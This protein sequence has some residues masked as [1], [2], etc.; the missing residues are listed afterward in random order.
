MDAR[1]T[2]ALKPLAV[3][4]ALANAQLASALVL[5]CPEQIH[6]NALNTGDTAETTTLQEAL[7][8][9][10]NCG[11]ESVVTINIADDL[12]GETEELSVGALSL[13]AS[14]SLTINGPSNGEFTI[15]TSVAD[16]VIMSINE[17]AVLAVNDVT[18]AGI[19]GVTRSASLF[20]VQGGQVSFSGVGFRDI[21][22][23]AAYSALYI[24]SPADIA[25]T[26]VTA[27]GNSSTSGVIGGYGNSVP[28]DTT[29]SVSDSVFTNN[30]A[31]TSRGGAIN[32]FDMDLTIEDSVF[33]SNTA[34]GDNGYSGGGAIYMGGET[35]IA[36]IRVSD[37]TFR[38]NQARNYGGAIYQSTG[39]TLT[40][41]D[42][43][44]E[45]NS[46][47]AASNEF[48]TGASAEAHGGA[49]TSDRST[50]VTITRTSFIGND[51]KSY[52][53]AVYVGRSGRNGTVSIEDSTFANNSASVSVSESTLANGGAIYTDAV[54]SDAYQLNIRRSTF[55]GNNAEGSAGALYA[56]GAG[57]GLLVENS[58][59]DANSAAEH[60]GGLYLGALPG[61]SISHVT[62]TDNSVMSDANIASGFIFASAPTEHIEIS[63]SVFHGN[64]T[65]N[66]A[67]GNICV[68]SEYSFDAQLSHSFWNGINN[69][70]VGCRTPVTDQTVISS[71]SDPL[72]G[73][74]QD[75]GGDTRTRYPALSSVLVDAGDANIQEAPD[76]DQRG[77]VRVSRGSIDIGAVEYGNLPPEVSAG[78]AVTVESGESISISLSDWFTDPEN[79][80]V[81]FTAEGA[82]SWLTLDSSTGEVT[83]TAGAAGSYDIEVTAQDEFG[84]T[85]SVTV[86]VVVSGNTDSSS[87]SSGGAIATWLLTLLGSLGLMRKRG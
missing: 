73:S 9:A 67:A 11:T 29:V 83:G 77:S 19:D 51:A 85:T 63:H 65:G 78:E 70:A 25:L 38:Q 37:S 18:F 22:G 23:T 36:R 80:S 69:D 17:S 41:E 71:V 20:N 56:G 6:V 33:D 79:D 55:S 59:F 75:N 60:S 42:T 76:T 58:T 47:I 64:T 16:Q 53:G 68:S 49:I 54:E 7:Q 10:L 26:D 31:T 61:A 24:S 35:G 8:T 72:L 5:E 87:S 12:A 4:I 15:T 48:G 43:V 34:T 21:V 50:D 74:L 13:D 1:S 66:D 57:V 62:A 86:S 82:P 32:A 84:L 44:F 46:V 3:V 14:K 45:D 81:S 39:D 52:G 28:G 40:I 2:L 30:S 27:S